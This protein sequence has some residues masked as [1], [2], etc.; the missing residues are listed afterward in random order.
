MHNP[1]GL[2]LD[3]NALFICEGDLGL[4]IFNASDIEEIDKNLIKH[5][6]SMNAYDVIPY[7]DNLIMIGMDGLYQYN[8]SSLDDIQYLS[9]LPIIQINE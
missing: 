2:G 6:N 4:K 5:Y 3:G 7:N 9:H 8:Y 1:H